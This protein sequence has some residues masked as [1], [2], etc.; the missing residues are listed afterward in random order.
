MV[1]YEVTPSKRDFDDLFEG[2]DK[3]HFSKHLDF[4]LESH[5]P[6]SFHLDLSFGGLRKTLGFD[7]IRG[8]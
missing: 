4:S 3:R 6:S 5:R 2:I 8:R 7:S 1:D